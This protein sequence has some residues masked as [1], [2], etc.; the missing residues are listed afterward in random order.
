MPGLDGVCSACHDDRDQ[1]LDG[2]G[3][4]SPRR[5]GRAGAAAPGHRRLP[6]RRADRRWAPGARL[7]GS[8]SWTSGP[9]AGRSTQRLGRRLAR[10]L[11][12]G[13]AGAP[14]SW[15]SLPTRPWQRRVLTG[16][17]RL[18]LHGAPLVLLVH[19]LRCSEPADRLSRAAASIVE[20]LALRVRRS[21]H[22]HQRDDRADRPA[23]D[24]T[25]AS[26]SRWCARAGTRTR[27]ASPPAAL[28]ARG[29][30]ST[31]SVAP[32]IRSQGR[33]LRAGGGGL[34]LLLVGHWTPRKGILDALAAV[35]R[36]GPGV[37]LDLVGEQDRDPTLR[38]AGTG[39]AARPGPAWQG[40]R[41]WPRL[42]RRPGR[43]VRSR[44]CARPAVDARGVRHGP[45]RG[46]GGRAAD[47]RDAR[48]RRAR[49][50]PRRAGGRAGAAR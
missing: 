31:G 39:G 9:P 29:E 18:A 8:A 45:G 16:R 15:T 48:R 13:S 30:G 37:S 20:T 1:P 26:P 23:P 4:Q 35:A 25:Q 10:A 47:R 22:L 6:V 14:S 32:L 41:A 38:R 28:P 3:N 34:R 27:M 49:G 46:A 42:L 24:A 44:R 2:P 12:A 36:L 19:H 43:A 17:L 50:R 5:L 40:A 33:A 11:S 21:R 7:D